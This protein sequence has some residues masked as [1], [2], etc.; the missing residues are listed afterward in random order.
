M[1]T[2]DLPSRVLDSRDW[3]FLGP[4]TS[5]DRHMLSFFGLVDNDQ[6]VWLLRSLP[7]KPSQWS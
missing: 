5:F 1:T 2:Q 4:R 6:H 7:F 3:I